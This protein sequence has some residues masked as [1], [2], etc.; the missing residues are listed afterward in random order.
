VGAAPKASKSASKAENQAEGVAFRIRPRKTVRARNGLRIDQLLVD[1]AGRKE[2]F[3][4]DEAHK[5]VEKLRARYDAQYIGNLTTTIQIDEG[6]RSSTMTPLNE[7]HQLMSYEDYDAFNEIYNGKMDEDMRIKTISIYIV[8]KSGKAGGCGQ[9]LGIEDEEEMNDCFVHSINA[10]RNSMRVK[11]INPATFKKALGLNRS[12]KVAVS[13]LPAA[14]DYLRMRIVVEDS[15]GRLVYKNKAKKGGQIIHLTLNQDHYTPAG[16]NK[17][18]EEAKAK[19]LYYKPENGTLHNRKKGYKLRVIH[20]ENGYVTSYDGKQIKRAKR[21]NHYKKGFHDVRHLSNAEAEELEKQLKEKYE[22][23]I[24]ENKEME[25]LTENRM[26]LRTTQ[27]LTHQGTRL[28]HLLSTSSKY[29]EPIRERAEVDLLRPQG[30]LYLV[31]EGEYDNCYYYD[32][33]SAYSALLAEKEFPISSGEWVVKEFEV[34]EKFAKPAYG[35]YE[36]SIEHK[37]EAEGFFRYSHRD[38]YTHIDIEAAKLLGLK[39]TPLRE[40]GKVNCYLYS[41]ITREK[42][43]KMFG[44]AIGYLYEM[45]KK[46]MPYAKPILASIWGQLTARNTEYEIFTLSSSEEEKDRLT[47]STSVKKIRRLDEDTISVEFFVEDER[48]S[49]RTSYARL[50]PFLTA[51]CRLE[52]LKAMQKV[53]LENI[54][55]VRTDGFVSKVEAEIVKIT[56]GQSDIGLFKLEKQGA[57]KIS[58]RKPD[59]NLP[60]PSNMKPFKG[61]EGTYYSKHREELKKRNIEPL[62]KL[63]TCECGLNVQ[64]R[65]KDS[66]LT[67]QLHADRLA[68]PDLYSTCECGEPILVKTRWNHL[69]TVKHRKLLAAKN[70]DLDG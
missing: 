7:P 1:P 59:F 21:A 58:S 49:F 30:G 55:Y 4:R 34:I 53:G 61:K 62:Q 22:Q 20:E 32:M 25:E 42:G 47:K 6:F 45:K 17:A 3:T 43:S 12:D 16:Y 46:K 66:H 13:K 27:K 44:P 8:I 33:N 51:F 50:G 40:D 52:M 2:F 65:H 26:S 10:A 19:E 14:E 11:R 67:S 54:V 48:G 18:K 37:E 69:R 41:Q 39:L 9:L 64:I 24:Q 31:R 28:I 70:I 5:V 15:E 60:R 29:A 56:L 63:E 68:F 38:L 57:V 23:V 35:F 36:I